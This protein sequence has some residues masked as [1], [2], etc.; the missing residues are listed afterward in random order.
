MLTVIAHYQ[1]QPNNGD[2]VAAALAKHISATRH[3]P[4]CVQFMGY[5]SR[6]DPDSFTL[7][8]QF[9]DQDSLDAHRQTPHF[10]RY[11]QQT[12]IPLLAVREFGL[13][14]EVAPEP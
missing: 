9:L 11:V 7:C 4:G 12:I 1:A 6:Q 14:D 13:Y 10:E 8:E 5:R 2:V 3:E